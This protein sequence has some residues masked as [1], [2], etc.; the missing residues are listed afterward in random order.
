MLADILIFADEQRIGS[1]GALL[2]A[3]FLISATASLQ[4]FSMIATRILYRSF[5]LSCSS[6]I[7]ARNTLFSR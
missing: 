2:C 3:A 7:P 4:F 6:W 1:S 5:S